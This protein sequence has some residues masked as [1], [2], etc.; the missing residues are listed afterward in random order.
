MNSP[1]GPGAEGSG[2]VGVGAADLEGIQNRLQ[3]QAKKWSEGVMGF[4]R[5]AAKAAGVEDVDKFGQSH[6]CA[7]S[8]SLVLRG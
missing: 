3:G 7:T 1:L 8:A 4:V 6:S 2:L 5:T